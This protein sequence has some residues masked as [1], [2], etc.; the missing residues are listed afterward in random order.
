MAVK[1]GRPTI[2]TPELGLEICKRLAEGESLR[3][4]CSSDEMPNRGTV[5]AWVLDGEHEE[6]SGQY[7]KAREIQAELLADQIIEISDTTKL[8]IINKLD[9]DGSVIETR[10]E[11]M[12][13]HRRL[14]VDSRKWYLSKVLPK[15]FGERTALELSGQ[16]GGPVQ[17]AFVVKGG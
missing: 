6:F 12:L 1:Q 16:N 10:E 11:D 9:K 7:A 5:I 2:F 15:K 8:G 14:Q 17:V 13:G 3:A 4:I